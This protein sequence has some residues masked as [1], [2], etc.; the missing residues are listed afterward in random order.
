MIIRENAEKKEFHAMTISTY[1][2]AWMIK[3]FLFFSEIKLK[4]WKDFLPDGLS[5]KIREV[6]LGHRCWQ[7][8]DVGTKWISNG[9][10]KD[11]TK[12]LVDLPHEY[13]KMVMSSLEVK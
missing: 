7:G 1:H 4:K 10:G 5:P 12:K 9:T 6:L 2:S 8:E 13:S 11:K 3:I